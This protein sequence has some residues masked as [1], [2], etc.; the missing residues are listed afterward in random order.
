[1]KSGEN[2]KKLSSFWIAPLVAGSCLA[3]GYEATQRIMIVIRQSKEP[4]IELFQTPNPLPGKGIEKLSQFSS[5]RHRTKLVNAKA[6]HLSEVTSN[7]AKNMQSML[8]ALEISWRDSI[9]TNQGQPRRPQNQ[10]KNP[11]VSSPRK[12]R[13]SQEPTYDKLFKSLRAP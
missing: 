12:Q 1:M 2:R 8:D 10:I 4:K 9:M 5:N 3:T 11:N 7:Q 6:K 13:N